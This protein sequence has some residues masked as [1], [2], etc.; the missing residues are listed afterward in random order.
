ML[1]KII[2]I[3]TMQMKKAFSPDILYSGLV[4]PCTCIGLYDF[5]SKSGYMIH[6]PEVE[7][8]D[9]KT[10]LN[11]VLADYGYLSSLK[12][13]V[14]GAATSYLES[15]IIKKDTL[16]N[17]IA[18]EKILDRKFSNSCINIDWFKEDHEGDLTLDISEGNF[19]IRQYNVLKN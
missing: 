10:K 15:G 1:P 3:H 5:S 18:A 9:L 11:R 4:R 6:V 19:Y 17:R 7:I 2:P 8:Q 16:R 14:I 13:Q 12:I